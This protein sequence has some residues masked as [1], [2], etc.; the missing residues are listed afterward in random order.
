MSRKPL[1]TDKVVRGLDK[2]L[3]HLPMSADTDEAAAALYLARLVEHTKSPEFAARQERRRTAVYAA[4]DKR[5][6]K[7]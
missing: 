5:K 7:S 6:E 1:L 3:G 4:R 2:L